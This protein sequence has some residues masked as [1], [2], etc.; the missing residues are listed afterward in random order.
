MRTLKVT[1]AG[2]ATAMIRDR[3][4]RN[5]VPGMARWRS[6]WR[7][8]KLRP[9]L[10]ATAALAAPFAPAADEQ[11]AV[12]E[13]AASLATGEH[14]DAINAALA[15]VDAIERR[16]GRY[17]IE[18][19]EPLLVLG[20]ALVGVGD[21]DGAFGA[22]GRAL[23]IARIGRGLHHPSQAPV[24]YRQ[25]ALFAKQGRGGKA[26][27]RHEYAYRT[28][29]RA[30]GPDDPRLLPGL[31]ALADWYLS[32]YNIFG[33]RALYERA[34]KLTR[35]A[36]DGHQA[37]VRALRWLA[38][39]YRAER[40][41]PYSV[42]AG[43][44]RDS[45]RDWNDSLGY[46]RRGGGK[47]PVNRFSRGERALIR[48]VRAVREQP[49]A[50]PA[51]V[52]A[53]LL[54]LGDWFLLFGKRDRALT[55]YRAV[56]RMLTPHERLLAEMFAAPTALYLPL[57]DDPRPQEGA[58]WNQ[59]RAGVVELALDVNANGLVANVETVR[60]EPE[61]VL[62]E[63]EDKVR[64]AVKRA[65]Y[66]PAFNGEALQATDNLRLV[67][68]FTYYPLGLLPPEPRRQEPSVPAAGARTPAVD[69]GQSVVAEAA[70]ED[71]GG[72]P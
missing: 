10:V 17:D 24:V 21:H 56:W 58:R 28:L 47:S 20:D 40:F 34:A 66:R 5:R 12:P 68:N 41:P 61:D 39:T 6:A 3:P 63:L 57:P 14:L 55:I 42:W 32:V 64:R 36:P 29:L 1:R 23:Q 72:A 9:W 33:A 67:H 13:A 15:V 18:L 49:D 60:A 37:H 45:W 4:D 69:A 2:V 16:G 7:Q 53:A 52:A 71:G 19:L 38:S 26:N 44:Q 50:R 25:A 59:P 8:R 35:Q 70:M 51:D 48:V 30:Y 62:E 31:F 11:R 54:E 43:E 27:Q 46:S 65:R 22:Y